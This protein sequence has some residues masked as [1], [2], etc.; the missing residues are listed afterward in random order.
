MLLKYIIFA[1]LATLLN[2][3]TQFLIFNIYFGSFKLYIAILAG[4]LVG[5]IFKYFLDR[6]YVFNQNITLKMKR[7]ATTFSLYSLM[8]VITTIVFWSI[9]ILFDYMIDYYWSKYLG[10]V[11][12][13]GVGYT[14]KFYLDKNFVFD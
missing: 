12:G 7:E 6:R 13:L 14:I 4:T 10:A 2:T 3:I 9:E 1:I 5:L 8:G 11:I